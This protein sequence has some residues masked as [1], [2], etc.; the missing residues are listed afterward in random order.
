MS[1]K[2]KILVDAYLKANPDMSPKIQY[3]EA[4]KLWRELKNDPENLNQKI[5]ELKAIA[6]KRDGKLLTMW[7]GFGAKR[8]PPS[9]SK[10]TEK[11]VCKILKNFR[12]T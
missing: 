5:I 4:Q 6:S 10:V 11:K 12:Q 1:D 3:L 9:T 7:S 2:Y 8:P